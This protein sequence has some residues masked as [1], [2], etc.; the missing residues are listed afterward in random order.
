MATKT[1]SWKQKLLFTGIITLFFLVIIIGIGELY[2]RFSFKPPTPHFDKGEIHEEI[3]WVPKANMDEHM[4]LVDGW[5]KPYHAHYR[6]TRDGFRAFGNP[7]SD[8]KKVFFIGDSFTQSVEVSNE[9]TFYQMLAD[10]LGFELFAFGHAGYGN[11]QEWMVL[12]RYFDEIQP[13]LVVLQVCDND[14]ID[15][16]LTVELQAGYQVGVRRPYLD[17]DGDIYYDRPIP[18]PERAL[19]F[20]KFLTLLYDRLKTVLPQ[21]QHDRDVQAE[22]RIAEEQRAY[23]PFDESVKITEM[24]MDRFLERID[25]KA[26]LIGFSASSFPVQ[27]AEHQRIF[28]D[29]SI[30]F[31]GTAAKAVEKASYSGVSTKAADGWHWNENGQEIIAE[32]L[33]PFLKKALSSN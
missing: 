30:P 5:D 11:L 4:D 31:D 33:M 16:H 3:G 18:K 12:D 19:Q 32:K 21:L 10:S 25:G 15:N 9:K 1:F 27:L 8:R 23:I 22:K 29:R 14:F 20:S 26:K 2:L 13:D 24:I 28:D 7:N 17:L 6:T